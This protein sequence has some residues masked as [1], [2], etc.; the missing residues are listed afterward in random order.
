MN[1]RKHGVCAIVWVAFLGLA[2]PACR[3]PSTVSSTPTMELS[4]SLPDTAEVRRSATSGALERVRGD[5]LSADIEQS[6]LFRESRLKG[7]YAGM[8][9]AFL[10]AFRDE[11]ALE[12][13]LAQFSVSRV[14]ADAIGFHQVRLYQTYRGLSVLDAEL[15]VHFDQ[16]DRIYLAEGHYLPT[17]ADLL[18]DTYMSQ[19]GARDMLANAIGNDAAIDAGEL[20]ILMPSSSTSARTVFRFEVRRGLADRREILLDAETGRMV[21]DVWALPAR[22][23]GVDRRGDVRSN[24]HSRPRREEGDLRA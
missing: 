14:N 22:R 4:A 10:A 1:E 11:F 24:D 7:D 19:Q 13:P 9:L 17:P 12:D 8:A 18:V 20:A 21:R 5:D 15:I 23:A 3:P 6:P 2:L 16:D